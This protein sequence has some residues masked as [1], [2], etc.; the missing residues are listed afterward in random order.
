MSPQCVLVAEGLLDHAQGQPPEAEAEA[1]AVVAAAKDALGISVAAT[2]AVAAAPPLL[3]ATAAA[4]AI[5][6]LEEV[7]QMPLLLR[8]VADEEIRSRVDLR[9]ALLLLLLLLL[10]GGCGTILLLQVSLW[11]RVS[12]SAPPSALLLGQVLG[13]AA[14]VAASCAV[15]AAAAAVAAGLRR[16]LTI[17]PPTARDLDDAVHIHPVVH[18]KDCPLASGKKEFELGIHIADVSHFVKTDGDIDKEARTRCSTL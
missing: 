9:G 5:W 14:V 16:V 3:A 12:S 8:F 10:A 7:M 13:A 11:L 2:S 4:A 15:T 17:D 6:C 18:A 1:T